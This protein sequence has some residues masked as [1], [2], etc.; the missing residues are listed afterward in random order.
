[1]ILGA[2]EVPAESR[3]A[4]TGDLQ[5]KVADAAPGAYL[6]AVRIDGIESPRVD[7]SASPPAFVGP[8]VVIT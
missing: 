5:F 8:T 4:T 1:L 7:R 3:T 2:R 6:I